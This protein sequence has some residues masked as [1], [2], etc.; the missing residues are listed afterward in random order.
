M[1]VAGAMCV[2]S[3]VTYSRGE[4]PVCRHG[5]GR[6]AVLVSFL[7][8]S[9]MVTVY[10]LPQILSFSNLLLGSGSKLPRLEGSDFSV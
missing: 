5:G 6:Q 1:L 9:S 3:V 10:L 4:L 8:S 2:T 7:T